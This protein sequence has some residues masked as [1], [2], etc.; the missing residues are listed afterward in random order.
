MATLP[1]TP[2]EPDGTVTAKGVRR[3]SLAGAL[4]AAGMVAYVIAEWPGRGA[5]VLE[6]VVVPALGMAYLL[7]YFWG[8]GA[9]LCRLP[10]LRSADPPEPL[11]VLGL[12]LGGA[13]SSLLVGGMAGGFGTVPFVVLSLGVIALGQWLLPL[14]RALRRP[15]PPTLLEWTLL[16]LIALFVLYLVAG[17]LMPMVELTS[18]DV[19]AY[20]LAMGRIYQEQGRIVNIPWMPQSNFPIVTDLIFFHSLLLGDDRLAVP[21]NVLL[22]LL[23]AAGV[24]S[25]T[26]LFVARAWSLLAA[27]AFLVTPASRLWVHNGYVEIG[28]TCFATLSLW[29]ALR[30]HARSDRPLHWL[31]FSAIF[32][33]LAVGTKVTAVFGAA[34]IG[35]LVLVWS[36]D[37]RRPG[38]ALAAGSRFA[39][40]LALVAAPVFV[41]T[42]LHIG[43]PV[44]PLSFGIFDVRHW[45]EEIHRRAVD[46]VTR[47]AG[48]AGLSPE[49]FFT[50]AWY[51][52]RELEFMLLILLAVGMLLRRQ[53]FRVAAPFLWVGTMGYLVLLMVTIQRRFFLPAVPAILMGLMVVTAPRSAARAEKVPFAVL[54]AAILLWSLPPWLTNPHSLL[55]VWALVSGAASREHYRERDPLFRASR[56]ARENTEPGDKIL[57]FGEVRGFFLGREYAWGDP[58]AQ[59]AVYYPQIPTPERL[60]RELRRQ[61]FSHVLLARPKLGT[62]VYPPRPLAL[63]ETVVLGGRLVA[64]RDDYELYDI[65]RIAPCFWRD[66]TG[67][68]VQAGIDDAKPAGG[69]R[70][71]V[72]HSAE[73]RYTNLLANPGFEDGVAGWQNENPWMIAPVD[74]GLLSPAAVRVALPPASPLVNFYQLRQKVAVEPGQLYAAGAYLRPRDLVVGRNSGATVEVLAFA[75]DGR[76]S[77]RATKRVTGTRD[78]TL[79]TVLF[80]VPAGVERVELFAPRIT[81]FHAGEITMDRAFLWKLDSC[82]RGRE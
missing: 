69:E 66:L 79:V 61:G 57:L 72:V 81:R 70:A 37:R 48:P 10:G 42:Y 47:I 56:M 44:W 30:W 50:L 62:D 74:G 29:C 43:T 36:F 6:N 38:A 13:A 7:A 39:L 2:L 60:H 27:L 76:K 77:W 52:R 14:R 35:V 25:G 64:F 46:L 71:A 16:L 78:W 32:S 63:M 1:L 67:A 5:L 3:R 80:R 26:R 22:Y 8:W 17:S 82:S 65:R 54:W 21:L 51:R 12:G 40:V 58:L 75:A 4:L 33:G 68:L 19:H 23:C 49:V 28:W 34:A 15:A 18:W 45:N 9:I 53:P 31:C 24:Y 11:A 41:K 55:E 20:H 59:T 73:R